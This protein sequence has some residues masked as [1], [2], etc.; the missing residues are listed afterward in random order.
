MEKISV[1]AVQGRVAFTA[2]RGGVRIPADKYVEV[3]KTPWIDR[4]LEVHG[5]IEAKGKTSS[6]KPTPKPEDAPKAD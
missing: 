6:K 4:L 2:A 1:K 3:D 5:D